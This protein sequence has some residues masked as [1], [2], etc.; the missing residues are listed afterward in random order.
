[1]EDQTIL[2]Q[3][4]HEE[5]TEL[6]ECQ[7]S[8]LIVADVRVLNKQQKSFNAVNRAGAIDQDLVISAY[9]PAETLEQNL[10]IGAGSEDIVWDFIRTHL[11][12]LPIFVSKNGKVEIISERQNFLLFDRMVA[13]HVQR[14]LTVPLSA[15]EFYS[16]LSQRYSE[17]DGMFFTPEQVAE[18]DRKR[19]TVRE[20][21]QLQL[22]VT[23]ENSAIQWMR[24]QLFKKPQ[25]S[26]EL[27]PQFMQE[28]AGWLKT[29][30]MLELDELLE[31]N[32]IKFDGQGPVPA[33]IHSYLSTNWKELRNL[34][35]NDP[36]LIAKARDRWYV[37]DPNKAGDLEKLRERA[38]L[39]E[40][41]EYKNAKKKLKKFRLEAVR[42]GF[43][44]AWQKHDYTTIIKV[45]EKIPNTVLEEDPKLLMWYDQ[46]VT[47]RGGESDG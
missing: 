27:K 33:Q 21:L 18:Y 9:K 31:Q 7:F 28:I 44:V 29:E 38:L 1:M 26:G 30:K 42:A 19:L 10:E 15:C 41:E 3:W 14:G 16:G 22:F 25:T 6:H 12:Q 11:N 23:D 4:C 35:K 2:F 45:A 36:T 47:R 37:P 24:Q 17:R 34:P 46:A 20:V 32:F 39:K 40:F 43:R 5:W 13:F 8:G